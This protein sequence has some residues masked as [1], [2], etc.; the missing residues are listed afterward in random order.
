MVLAA[1][2]MQLLWRGFWQGAVAELLAGGCWEV[3]QPTVLRSHTRWAPHSSIR[4]ILR[5]SIRRLSEGERP[6]RD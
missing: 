2:T 3:Q 1:E 4:R 6:A 5:S